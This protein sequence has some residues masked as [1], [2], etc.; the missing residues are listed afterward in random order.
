MVLWTQAQDPS[1]NDSMAVGTSSV[2]VSYARNQDVPRKV[3]AVRNVSGSTSD[4][5]SFTLGNNPAVAG[6]GIV[7]RQYESWTDAEDGSYKPWQ[8]TINAI[9]ATANGQIAVFE[10]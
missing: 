3:I 2:T 1:R 4:I 7:L 8:G 10:R 5:I 9:C 6:K